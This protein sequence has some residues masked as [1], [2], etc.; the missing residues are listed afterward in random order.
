MT[1]TGR[2]VRQEEIIAKLGG[3]KSRFPSAIARA[4]E[5]DLLKQRGSGRKG[6]PRRFVA[7]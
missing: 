7:A 5:M 2:E 3:D 1:E 4:L 6:D